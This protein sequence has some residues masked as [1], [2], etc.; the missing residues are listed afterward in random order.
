MEYDNGPESL[1]SFVQ[2]KK[3]K[4]PEGEDYKDQWE[5]VICPAIH[6]KYVTT[7][8]NLNNE[9][10][11]TYKNKCMLMRTKFFQYY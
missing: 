9:I 4:I 3:V 6:T 5:S 1:P 10:R 11:K 7:K 2:G 8:C